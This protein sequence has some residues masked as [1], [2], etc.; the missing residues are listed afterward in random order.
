MF[1]F[2][3][4]FL[5]RP[6]QS[7]ED[8]LPVLITVGILVL[9]FM[10]VWVLSNTVRA[11]KI[12]Q[13]NWK[14]FFSLANRYG[15]NSKEVFV[16]RNLLAEANSSIPSRYLMEADRFEKL[17]TRTQKSALADDRCIESIR[18]KLFG[19]FV[20]P[21]DM[22]ATTREI[23]AGVQ[24]HIVNMKCQSQIITGRIIDVDSRGLV[25][26]FP[27]RS[28]NASLLRPDTQLEVTAYLRNHA[29]V[30]FMTWIESIIPGPK[31]MAVLGHADFV[32]E[33]GARQGGE[34]LV[35]PHVWRQDAGRMAP[36]GYAHA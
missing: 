30:Q 35:S 13:Q 10:M 26:V 29:P 12:K 19:D 23:P 4:Q 31:K 15:L 3:N 33:K 16:M 28:F 17:V 5:F 24:L 27:P 1:R 25:V 8:F 14:K 2:P 18:G 21:K 7:L 9:F 22:V 34:R 11:N 32:V 20:Q 6:T 36:S